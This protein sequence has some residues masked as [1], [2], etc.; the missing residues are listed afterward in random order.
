MLTYCIL[1]THFLRNKSLKLK[2]VHLQLSQ[3]DLLNTV[4]SIKK[5]I[6]NFLLRVERYRTTVLNICNK[7]R[8]V[9]L[10][11]CTATFVLLLH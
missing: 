10:K 4:L 8:L 6:L 7:K 2:R 11:N 1:N 5:E 3:Y 9:L